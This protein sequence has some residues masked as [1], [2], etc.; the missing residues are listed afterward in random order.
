MDA[1]LTVL[2]AILGF[3][4]IYTTFPI[5]MS[6]LARKILRDQS[7][8]GLSIKT[9]AEDHSKG[10]LEGERARTSIVGRQRFF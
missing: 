10:T 3:I 2:L 1:G 9:T 8:N 5:F 4:I 7:I 6:F